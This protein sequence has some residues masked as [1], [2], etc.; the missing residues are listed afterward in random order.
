MGEVVVSLV[1][2]SII[3]L[4]NQTNPT[5]IADLISKRSHN[6]KSAWMTKKNNNNN[7]VNPLTFFL[8]F[9]QGKVFEKTTVKVKQ[10]KRCE[11][12]KM[13]Y[14]AIGVGVAAGI[15]ILA[16]IITFNLWWPKQK[17][18]HVKGKRHR[19]TSNKWRSRKRRTVT[20]GWGFQWFIWSAQTSVFIWDIYGSM[21]PGLYWFK[22]SGDMVPLVVRLHP[23]FYSFYL[24]LHSA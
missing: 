17:L 21:I 16:I 20:G 18:W 2:I 23:P 6:T 1:T 9:P 22:Y 15:I 10:Q 4:F 13:K 12:K 14:I 3:E 11:N 19:R 7:K 8:S 5:E 24:P